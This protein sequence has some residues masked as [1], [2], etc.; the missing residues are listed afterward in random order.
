MTPPE[1]IEVKLAFMSDDTARVFAVL[2]LRDPAKSERRI[3]SS[4][5]QNW[6]FLIV[7]WSSA[8]GKRCQVM[9][10]RDTTL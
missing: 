7:G 9:I 5:L 4:T 6:S 2:G 10:R 8:R 3:H 1:N